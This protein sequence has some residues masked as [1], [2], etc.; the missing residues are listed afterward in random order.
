MNSTFQVAV[1]VSAL[2]AA[3]AQLVGNEEQAVQQKEAP[4]QPSSGIRLMRVETRSDGSL[5]DLDQETGHAPHRYSAGCDYDEWTQWTACD[6]TCGKATSTRDRRSLSNNSDCAA[7]NQESRLCS[8]VPCPVDCD[9]KDWQGWSACS[10]TCGNGIKSNKRNTIAAQFGGQPCAGAFEK[11]MDCQLAPC[12]SECQ[13]TEWNEWP[14]CD[15]TCGG[16][17]EQR[18]R[19]L[20]TPSTNANACEGPCDEERECAQNVCPTDCIL[21]DWNDWEACNVSCG[22]G[23]AT[24]IRPVEQQMAYGGNPCGYRIETHVCNKGACL[25]PCVWNDWDSW[26][27]CSASCGDGVQRR[28]RTLSAD[29]NDACPGQP[30]EARVCKSKPCSQDCQVSDWSAWSSCSASC[31]QGTM[32]RSRFIHKAVDGGKPCPHDL[33][34]YD[35][36]SCIKDP[37]AKPCVWESWSEW[38]SCS[39]SCGDGVSTRK[40]GCCSEEDEAGQQTCGKQDIENRTCNMADCPVDC[41]WGCWSDWF[42]CSATC[43]LGNQTRTRVEQ[44]RSSAGGKPCEGFS[45]DTASCKVAECP[46][47]C[48]WLDWSTWTNCSS[49]CGVG[50][51]SRHR[52]TL[53]AR[54]GGLNCEGNDTQTKDCDNL[55]ECKKDCV[56]GE[57]TDWQPCSASCGSGFER[58]TRLRKSYE[59]GGGKNCQGMEDDERT[60]T[61]KACPSDCKMSDWGAWS[62]CSN[63]CGQ[64][65][66]T[67]QRATVKEALLSGSECN[68][69]TEVTSCV[70]GQCA[71]DCKWDT[72][73]AWSSCSKSCGGGYTSRS[74]IELVPAA[75][76]GH[77]CEGSANEETVCNAMPCP[78]DCAWEQWSDWTTCSAS[79]GVA[80]RTRARAVLSSAKF[81]GADCAGETEE[82]ELCNTEICPIDCQWSSWTEW[83][84]CSATCDGGETARNRRKMSLAQHG[85]MPCVGEY[86]EQKSCNTGGCPRDCEWGPWSSWSPCEV[87]CGG[88]SIKRFRDIS[89]YKKNNGSDCMGPFEEDAD[90][91]ND[92]CPQNCVW[93]DWSPW[94][95]C[96]VT[97]G[98]ATRSSSRA[99]VQ[100][101]AAGGEACVNQ[102][103]RQEKCGDGPCPFDCLLID[104]NDWGTCSTSCGQGTAIRTR[105]KMDERNG[106]KTCDEPLSELK[107]C[108]NEDNALCPYTTSTTTLRAIIYIPEPGDDPL[109]LGRFHT[110]APGS[111]GP[112]TEYNQPADRS[113]STGNKAPEPCA[114]RT[115]S[116][117]NDPKLAKVVRKPCSKDDLKAALDSYGSFAAG[118][119]S[120]VIEHLIQVKGMARAKAGNGEKE[121]K[122]VSEV[123]GQLQL[124]VS[125]ADEFIAVPEAK[126]AVQKA[127]SHLAKVQEKNLKVELSLEGTFAQPLWQKKL[128]GN[129][130][131]SYTMQVFENDNIGDSNTLASRMTK[132]DMNTDKVTDALESALADA[133][134][135]RFSQKATSLS[136]SIREVP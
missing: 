128:K 134:L 23:T 52:E 129:V 12:N 27:C 83:S 124:Y 82:K 67:R 7:G 71:I 68:A 11:V 75:Y 86:S 136:V 95:P 126:T 79:C 125:E 89:V 49:L 109:G 122:L 30:E 116:D 61:Q 10:A 17:K 88:G 5:T 113:D 65:Q 60:C 132:K 130:V 103:T 111:R 39:Q 100:E 36:M 47:N 1:F 104:W 8:Q 102:S 25:E 32:D 81:G 78:R 72:W 119:L 94:P 14:G 63:T 77:P 56:W 41:A 18:H 21:G 54:N 57:W 114:T 99:K 76:G 55:P 53:P 44:T 106:G 59:K 45:E 98:G 66:R 22:A 69:T 73:H 51:V 115:A 117:G 96:P 84:V 74:R 92:A 42:S 91:N 97:C 38:T 105:V 19:T 34:S 33:R 50:S 46:E 70:L 120:A 118:N 58:K 24:R 16:G 87:T 9:W 123:S 2:A 20:L 93:D 43:G 108:T 28:S 133:G 4:A 85:G 40:R 6:K 112:K 64:G 90:C 48:Q 31:G 62:S 107:V 13:W 80:E 3:G 15:Q 127:L 29:S 121:G 110:S 101:A 135:Q 37:C 35:Q 131:A 26:T